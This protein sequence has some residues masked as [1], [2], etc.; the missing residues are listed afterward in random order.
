MLR[1]AK[2]I[3]FP[4][5]IGL[6]A[7]LPTACDSDGVGPG[8]IGS[9]PNEVEGEWLGTLPVGGQVEIKGVN[10][11]IEIEHT[12]GE[13]TVVAFAKRGRDG[14][15]VRIVVVEHAGGTGVTVCAMYPNRPGEPENRCVV[16]QDGQS[17]NTGFGNIDA[18]VDFFIQLPPGVNITANTINGGISGANL[19]SEVIAATVNG[20]IHLTTSELAAAATVNGQINVEMSGVIDR[21]LR[22]TTVNGSI[23]LAVQR[24]NEADYTTSALNGT[25]TIFGANIIGAG[26]PPTVH[27]TIGDGGPR[28]SLTT[29]NGSIALNRL[30]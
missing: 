23:T 1:T 26:V 21:N 11:G 28:L 13:E 4:V 12:E 27:G 8:D 20:S 2:I 22:Y 6:L 3:V 29:I 30:P 7:S 5:L 24:N 9:D 10:G 18:E 25:L 16:G 19:A 15:R 17:R 14:D